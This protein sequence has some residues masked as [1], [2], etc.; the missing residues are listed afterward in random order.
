MCL[1]E[2]YN[3]QHSYNVNTGKF[4]CPE[5][6]VYEF[7]FHCTIYNN[8]GNIDLLRNRELVLHSFTTKQNDLITARG[9]TFLKLEK[10][11]QVYLR[12]NFAGNGLTS[13]SFFSGHL[14]FTE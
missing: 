9:N 8:A 6:G 4:I 12:T 2:I 10:G 13:D 11:D 14:L 5:A 7:Q 3:G 1:E